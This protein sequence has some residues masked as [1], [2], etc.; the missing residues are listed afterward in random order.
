MAEDKKAPSTPRTRPE[1]LIEDRGLPPIQQTRP[2]PMVK[3]PKKETP[4]KN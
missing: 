4:K 2:M 1:P 3:P